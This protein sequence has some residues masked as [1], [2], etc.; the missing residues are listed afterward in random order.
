[1]K[2]TIHKKVE[3]KFVGKKKRLIEQIKKLEEEEEEASG[4]FDSK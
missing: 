2:E 4:A 1:M 3:D